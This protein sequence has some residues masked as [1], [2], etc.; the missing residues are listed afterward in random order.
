MS[1]MEELDC[2][3]FKTRDHEWGLD[4]VPRTHKFKNT[5]T[6]N[7]CMV[8]ESIIDNVTQELQFAN[9]KNIP[10]FNKILKTLLYGNTKL[11]TAF[12]KTIKDSCKDLWTNI[13]ERDY[14]HDSNNIPGLQT[15]TNFKLALE[16]YQE[17][18]VNKV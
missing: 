1:T 2:D 9:D 3:P 13:T 8:E 6:N 17:A 7:K 5:F 16:K 18:I 14:I 12:A 11:F 10:S 15:T 4:S